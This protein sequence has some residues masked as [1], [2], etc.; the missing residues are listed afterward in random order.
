MLVRHVKVGILVELRLKKGKPYFV[1]KTASLHYRGRYSKVEGVF[2]HY[3]I[4]GL[5]REVMWRRICWIV[6]SSQ[7]D[8][9]SQCQREGQIK[10]SEVGIDATLFKG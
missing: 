3:T 5:V 8:V 9:G 6:T 1:L 10:V 7:R 2:D 4:A